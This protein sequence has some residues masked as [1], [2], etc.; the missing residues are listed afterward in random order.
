MAN[1]IRPFLSPEDTVT[2][3]RAL[4]DPRRYDI[5]RELAASVG[6]VACCTLAQA[7]QVGAS[8]MSHHLQ[9]LELA[10]LIDVSR[11]GKFAVLRLVRPRYEAFVRQLV[12]DARLEASTGAGIV[13]TG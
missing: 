3:L 13:R 5:V 1:F 12:A 6:P 2:V 9:Q 8:T 11:D 7:G 10:G 4:A